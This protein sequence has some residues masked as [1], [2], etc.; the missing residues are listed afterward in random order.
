[1]YLLCVEVCAEEGG[2]SLDDD[3]MSDAIDFV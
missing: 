1:L 2:A 3:G